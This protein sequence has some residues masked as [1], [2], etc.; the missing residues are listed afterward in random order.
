MTDADKLSLFIVGKSKRFRC[1]KVVKTAF[2]NYA[3]KRK[4]CTTKILKILLKKVN[5]NM[6]NCAAHT[7]L[8]TL[9]NVKVLP[10]NT[11][12]TPTFR[13]RYRTHI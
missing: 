5:N 10:V 2:A 13:S 6:K 7:E 9:L 8:Q 3:D 12:S 11:T 1:L 4:S